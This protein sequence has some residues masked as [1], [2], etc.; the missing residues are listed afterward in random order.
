MEQG[1]TSPGGPCSL[2]IQDRDKFTACHQ[3]YPCVFPLQT[4]SAASWPE[5][6]C[7]AK[8]NQR[9]FEDFPGREG[10]GG[11]GKTSSLSAPWGRGCLVAGLGGSASSI[12]G[13]EGSLVPCDGNL[14]S[15]S[16]FLLFNN[17]WMRAA[18]ACQTN[19]LHKN[20]TVGTRSICP[21]SAL[22]ENVPTGRA[23]WE[24]GPACRSHE[25]LVRIRVPAFADRSRSRSCGAAVLEA[26]S[27][28]GGG[29]AFVG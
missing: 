29:R 11:G 8:D 17:K 28:G 24:G 5:Q 22:R 13:K 4:G 12:L 1:R 6:G 21:P 18:W 15:A 10:E 2:Q 3:Q 7:H 9:A 20:S 23:A 27:Q 19:S 26:A 16:E 14:G 25:C